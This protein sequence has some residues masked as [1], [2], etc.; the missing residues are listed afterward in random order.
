[1]TAPLESQNGWKYYKFHEKSGHTTTECLEL[2]KTLHE[3]ADKGQ[4]D[5]F[6]KRG[7]Q[8]LRQ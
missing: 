8:F 2:K 4:I 6:L 7:P 3:L 5:R 1:M